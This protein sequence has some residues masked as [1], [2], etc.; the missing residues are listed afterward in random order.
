MMRL[1]FEA[2]NIVRR[3]DILNGAAY[4]FPGGL[5]PKPA[6]RKTGSCVLANFFSKNSKLAAS[7][8]TASTIFIFSL[9]CVANGMDDKGENVA[10]QMWIAFMAKDAMH[11]RSHDFV[12]LLG[13]GF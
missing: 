5:I 4:A 6:D 11:Q 1:S 13:I 7:R 8:V 2:S 9:L 10:N 3:D 12:W